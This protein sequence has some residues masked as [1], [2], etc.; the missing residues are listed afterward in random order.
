MPSDRNGRLSD[1]AGRGVDQHAVARP[2]PG[3][4][5]QRVPGGAVSGGDRGGLLDG[6][7]GRQCRDQPCVTGDIRA[8]ASACAETADFVADS[9]FGDSRPDGGDHTR[10]IQAELGLLA[11]E[12]RVSAEGGQ[13]IGEVDAGGAD[14]D[15]DLSGCRC[16]PL[17][18]DQLQGLQ[19]TGVADLQAHAVGFGVGEGGP[20]LLGAQRCPPQPRRVPRSR[21]PGCFVLGRAA[22]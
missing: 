9:V 12:R 11:V 10:E 2:D 8:P 7:A 21:A 1:T 22:Q 6:Q 16:G 18:C 20:P 14:G 19:I 4:V 5:A 13:H 17:G 3:E 15:F